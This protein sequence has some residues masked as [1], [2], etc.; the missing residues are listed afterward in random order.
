MSPKVNKHLLLWASL[1]TLGL[2]VGAAYRE[3]VLQEW[4]VHQ[5]AYQGLLPADAAG[6]FRVQLRQIVSPNLRA[7]DR[8]VSCHVGMAPGEAPIEG[9][10]L[11]GKHPDVIHD[12]ADFGCV[13]CHAGQG[14]ATERKAAHGDVPHWPE[15]MI[16][17]RFAFAGCG[18]CHTHL[19]VPNLAT[20]ERGR[21]L[22]ERFDCLAC[23]RIEGRGG[24]LRPL[25][26]GG[27]EGP[28]LSRVGAQGFDRGWYEGHLAKSRSDPAPAWRNSFGEMLPAERQALDA[29]LGSRVGAPGLVEA[30]ALFHTLG[31]RG[32]H[33]V[34]GVGGDDG[35]DLTRVGQ[36]DPGQLD[37]SRVHGEHSVGNWL[38]EHFK[39]PSRVVAGS[40][41]PELG[42]REQE[43][44]LL[45]F[46]MFALRRAEVPEALWPTDRIRAERFGQR[47]FATDGA[48]L[49]GTFC[50]SCHGLRG[51]GM[52]F[53]G[54]AAFPAI[55]HPG[56]LALASDEFLAATILRGRP[57]RRMPAWG[58]QEGGLQPA[59][60]SALIAHLRQ[61]G[62]V[63]APE[64]DPRPARWV[65][66][67][68]ARGAEIFAAACA[69]CHGKRG[70]GGEGPALANAVLLRHATDH[71]L[72][73]TIRRG[74]AGTSMPEFGKGD[75]VVP[76]LSDIEIQSVVAYIRQWE[77]AP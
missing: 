43:L 8:C 35:P 71:Y 10:Q 13:V 75:S 42:L 63:A 44:D 17:Q 30:K 68:T 26:A 12:P 1:A 69:S 9:H 18:S 76:T 19:E 64:P 2:L 47:E 66:G 23:H 72:V 38:R 22:L 7:T 36:R 33:K 29:F 34:G 6:E 70:E 25:G 65:Q 28:D 27:M 62:A 20:V 77:V 41:M 15:P 61:L 45:V 57:G 56:F 52:R 60:I 67:D 55:A 51:E 58:A 73:E 4:R 39:A 59:D 40:V 37:F 5:R 46:Y 24:T 32:C 3:N 31:C 14:R 16:P 53:A 48:T 74:R 54:V 49:Y 50:A 21:A 11:F